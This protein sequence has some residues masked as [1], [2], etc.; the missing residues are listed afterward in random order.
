[1]LHIWMCL[2]YL[3]GEAGEINV[4]QLNYRLMKN[5]TYYLSKDKTLPKF[6]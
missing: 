4:V 3:H 6:I 5:Y 2:G 1:M